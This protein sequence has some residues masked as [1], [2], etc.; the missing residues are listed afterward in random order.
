MLNEIYIVITDQAGDSIVN[1]KAT[2]GS[3]ECN[4]LLAEPYLLQRLVRDAKESIEMGIELQNK[5]PLNLG[6]DLDN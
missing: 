4:E 6:V 3:E 2:I 5:V 1:V